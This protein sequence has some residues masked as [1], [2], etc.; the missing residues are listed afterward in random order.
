M[1][2]VKRKIS[3]LRKN[4]AQP[5]KNA[6]PETPQPGAS[7]L[8]KQRQSRPEKADKWTPITVKQIKTQGFHRDPQAKNLYLQVSKFNGSKNWVFRFKSPITGKSR[9]LGLGGVDAI[10]LAKAR[11]L[12]S[13]ARETVALGNDPLIERHTT[14]NAKR[15]AYAR[16]LASRMTFADCASAYLAEHLSTFR[17]DK[18]RQQWQS[19]LDRA[20]KA[21]GGVAVNDIGVDMIVKFLSPIWQATPE[22]ASR[23]R[24]RVERVLDWATARQFR[25]GE[26]PA[27]WRGHLQHLLKA[28]PKVKHHAALP[29]VEL[30]VFMAE[31]RERQSISAR[32]LE[33]AILTVSRTNETIGARWDEIEGDVWVVPAERMKSGRPHR[34]PLPRRAREILDAL[35]RDPSGFVF[36]GPSGGKPLSNMAML[37]LLKGMNGG[38]LTVHGFRSTFKDWSRERSTFAREIVEAALAH[39]IGDKTEAAYVRG[40]A[41]AKRGRLMEAWAKF[42]ATP[43]PKAAATVTPIRRPVLRS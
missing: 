15:E 16:E 31:L 22:S 23:I 42:A 1:I 18:H 4:P 13:N 14:Q 30:P 37:Q 10:S 38:G 3:R 9:W 17:N 43:A 24:G 11:E 34:V 33:F 20:S 40:D 21:F 35:P 26:N 12:A 2:V 39:V 36:P 6:P 41:L 28:R 5:I 29:Y 32:A 7:H 19:S 25:L 27:R 8:R